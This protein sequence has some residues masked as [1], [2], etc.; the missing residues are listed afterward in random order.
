[1]IDRSLVEC[2]LHLFVFV[3][4]IRPSRRRN[5][6]QSQYSNTLTSSSPSNSPLVKRQQV[7]PNK[8][9]HRSKSDATALTGMKRSMSTNSPR[10]RMRVETKL[11]PIRSSS[12]DLTSG[13]AFDNGCT[14]HM[15]SEGVKN[16]LVGKSYHSSHYPSYKSNLS[17]SS[18]NKMPFTFMPR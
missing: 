18:Q 12:G 1:M 14:C 4:S 7:L 16:D 3:F 11:L 2:K 5:I 15:S 8:T 6:S 10:G 13:R 17:L 9:H